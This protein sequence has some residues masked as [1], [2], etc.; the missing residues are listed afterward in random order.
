[1]GRLWHLQVGYELEVGELMEV[2]HCAVPEGCGGR[3]RSA[4][5][6]MEG[7]VGC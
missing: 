1:M 6:A 2:V 5:G 4:R 3:V 7:N